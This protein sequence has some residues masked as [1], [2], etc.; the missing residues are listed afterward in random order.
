MLELKKR[1]D[2][3]KYLDKIGK[4]LEGLKTK[5]YSHYLRGLE[6]FLVVSESKV[7]WHFRIN[8]LTQTYI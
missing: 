1:R 6:I 3:S 5:L 4:R 8:Q 2:F 7:M